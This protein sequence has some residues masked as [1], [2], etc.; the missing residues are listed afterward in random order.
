MN[1]ASSC[2]S[3]DE[4]TS[5]RAISGQT[6]ATHP[7]DLLLNDSKVAASKVNSAVDLVAPFEHLRM[8]DVETVGGKNASLGEMI[9]QLAEVGVR[10]PGGFATTALAFRQFLRENNLTQRIAER[11][12]T[13]NVDDVKALAECGAQIRGWVIDAPLP[14]ALE[15]GIRD[16]YAQMLSKQVTGDEQKSRMLE[17]ISSP[18]LSSI[19]PSLGTD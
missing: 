15:Q 2:L 12:S 1:Q 10:V 9:S 7:V 14:Q 5:K 11:L 6:L 19:R 8:G 18:W 3:G 16:S 13:L 4:A 17:K